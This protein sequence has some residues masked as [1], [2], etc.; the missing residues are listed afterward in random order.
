LGLQGTTTAGIK[1]VPQQYPTIQSGINAAVNGDTVLVAPGTYHDNITF[2]GKG[3]IVASNFLNNNDTSIV[4]STIL[5]G[6]TPVYP[7]SASCLRITSKLSSTCADTT[8]MLMGCTITNGTGTRWE[9]EHNPGN[10]LMG[11]LTTIFTGTPEH[12]PGNLTNHT[13][14]IAPNPCT[15]KVM[16][17]FSV[18]RQQKVTI[19]IIDRNGRTL[20]SPLETNA[21][22]GINKMEIDV[23]DLKPGNYLLR[24]SSES[25]AEVAGFVKVQE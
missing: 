16:V 14:N 18:K 11:N 17:T 2:L 6:S 19:N 21:N 23:H 8:A 4:S 13:I 24:V 15:S 5:D 9:D 7:D 25:S 20:L 3:I 22:T 1:Q 12:D 10:S